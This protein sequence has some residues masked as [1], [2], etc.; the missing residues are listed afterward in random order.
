MANPNDREIIARQMFVAP[1]SPRHQPTVVCGGC[2]THNRHTRVAVNEAYQ[3]K[4]PVS[5][6]GTTFDSRP[7]TPTGGR[8]G[9][10]QFGR[11]AFVRTETRWACAACALRFPIAAYP[12][13][14]TAFQERCRAGRR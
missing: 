11:R 8:L 9:T 3:I 7:R 12:G 10:P 6:G 1:T 5:R 13:R 14:D 4:I 2:E